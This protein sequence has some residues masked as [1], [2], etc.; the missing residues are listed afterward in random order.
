VSC[1]RAI[2]EP[3]VADY[4]TRPSRQ[5]LTSVPVNAAATRTERHWTVTE[6][7]HSLISTL[8]K[9]CHEDINSDF[10]WSSFKRRNNSHHLFIKSFSLVSVLDSRL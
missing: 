2:A 5:I 9:W 1:L 10:S 8:H 3:D 4:I 6:L 7:F